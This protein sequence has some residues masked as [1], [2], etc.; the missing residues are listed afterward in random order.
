MDYEFDYLVFIG[1]FQPLHNGHLYVMNEALKKSKNL[2][3][4]VGSAENPRSIRNPWTFD[5]RREMIYG[6]LV[7]TPEIRDRV[8][9][10]PIRDITYNDQ[11]WINQIQKTVDQIVLADLNQGSPHVHLHGLNN[12]RIGLVGFQKDGSSYYL[13]KFP[14][15]ESYGI[16][17]QHSTFDATGIRD[18]YFQS[19]PTIPDLV[20]PS[21]TRN[22]LKK[23]FLY[24]PEFKTILNEYTA[25]RAYKKAWENSPFPPIFVTT[26][27]VVIQSGHILLI[28]RGDFPG[29][30]LM[31]LPGGFLDANEKVKD[32]AVRELKEET[33]IADHHG[34]IPP[35][36]LRSFI[37]SQRVF[38]DPHRSTRGRTI[39][40][41]FRFDLPEATSLYNVIGSDDAVHAEWVRLSDVKQDDMY[42][43]HFHIIREMTGGV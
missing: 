17:D 25:I 22:L 34:E 8:H 19:T 23:E 31:A 1:R 30:G 16:E 3:I 28:R 35:A 11:A 33:R 7:R 14:Q 29:K 6:D 10:A 37:T 32:C 40:H 42:E 12:A 5:E 36:K 4:L 38:D 39:T 9:V 2:I 27:C 43:D 20:V 21:A 24:R 41:A 18:A 26:D 15:W 13:K